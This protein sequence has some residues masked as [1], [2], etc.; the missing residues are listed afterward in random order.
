MRK[1]V[2]KAIVLMVESDG[3]E[4]RHEGTT[5]D[6]SEHGARVEAEAAL[7][8]GQTLSLIQ[9]DDPVHV[10]RCLVVWSG[11]VS[12]DGHGQAGLEFLDPPPAG[13]EN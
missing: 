4:V 13:L 9:A 5:V 8:P 3:P 7:A 2:R 10:L 6:M 11:D 12:S 1:P